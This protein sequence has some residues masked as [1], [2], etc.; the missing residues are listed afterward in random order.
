MAFC[1][2]FDISAWLIYLIRKTERTSTGA[3]L[4]YMSYA[5]QVRQI[6]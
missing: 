4:K 1:D 6:Q 3:E 2:R 5:V